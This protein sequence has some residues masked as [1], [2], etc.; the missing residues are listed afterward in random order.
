MWN[1][2]VNLILCG[3]TQSLYLRIICTPYF[4]F[5]LPRRA[6]S[7][8]SPFWLAHGVATVQA[9]VPA[10]PSWKRAFYLR[11]RRDKQLQGAV[12]TFSKYAGPEFPGPSRCHP[13]RPRR[14][15]AAATPGFSRW[16]R[17]PGLTRESSDLPRGRRPRGKPGAGRARGGS[18]Q[19]R[20]G[21][22]GLGFGI[23]DWGLGTSS[24]CPR[25]WSGAPRGSHT[26][27][28][29]HQP[30]G[31]TIL[32]QIRTVDENNGYFTVTDPLIKTSVNYRG[33]PGAKFT[34]CVR[35]GEFLWR[36]CIL[37]TLSPWDLMISLVG[38]KREGN[39]L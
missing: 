15:L 5:S 11:L 27:P 20:S 2:K 6:G 33:L 21:R 9:T 32:S 7:L 22:R 30:S 18:T 34:A 24:G 8:W 29:R 4:Q 25:A 23:W 31:L 3:H 14:P 12:A 16:P 37:N 13:T 39:W 1:I 36:E 10:S 38:N 26:E 17:R 28:R 19:S 35:V